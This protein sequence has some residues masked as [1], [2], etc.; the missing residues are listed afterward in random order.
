MPRR[1]RRTLYTIFKLKSESGPENGPS[2]VYWS[3][4][5]MQQAAAVGGV[6]HSLA[7]VPPNGN[8]DA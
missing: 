6:Y 7:F 5:F 8:G 4:C 2:D 1:G 3:D